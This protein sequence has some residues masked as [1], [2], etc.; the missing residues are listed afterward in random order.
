[1]AKLEFARNWWSQNMLATIERMSDSARLG[2]G[3]SYARGGKIKSL[4]IEGNRILAQVRG[5]VNPY[6]GVYREP[7]YFTTIEFKQ[8]SLPEWREIIKLIGSKAGFLSRLMVYEL[9]E[10]IEEPF[11]SLG[12]RLLPLNSQ[13][14]KIS[15][16]CPDY[17]GLC[18][19][20]I[21]VYYRLV[22]AI[23]QDPFLLFELRGMPREELQAALQATPLGQG[24]AQE[25]EASPIEPEPVESYFPRPELVPLQAMDVHHFWM[26]TKRLPKEIQVPPAS[27][28][29]GILIKKQGDAP[30]FWEGSESFLAVMDELYDRVKTK[31]KD[32][33]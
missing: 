11:K 1:M 15:C 23:D 22:V 29:S 28:V 7:T 31:N 20:G 19:H 12:L 21:G 25:L 3:R 13:D 14:F 8:F 18:K 27:P 4:D 9:P 32:L 6:F 17:Y 16:S 10:N 24:L 5:S 30:L 2:R 26:G 33:F